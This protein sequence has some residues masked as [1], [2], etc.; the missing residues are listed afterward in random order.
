MILCIPMYIHVCTEY[1][2][3]AMALRVEMGM[4]VFKATTGRLSPEYAMTCRQSIGNGKCSSVLNWQAWNPRKMM[5]HKSKGSTKFTTSQPQAKSSNGSWH[6]R[7][8]Y[9]TSF[10]RSF[11]SS[12]Q[13][14]VSFKVICCGCNTT[15]PKLHHTTRGNGG[16]V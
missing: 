14:R 9:S 13:N 3:L 16:G 8:I 11:Q 2:T 1:D 12:Y 4:S 15:Q 10:F 5:T 7:F 6:S